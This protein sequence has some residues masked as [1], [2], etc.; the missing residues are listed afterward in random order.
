MVLLTSN[1][2]DTCASDRVTTLFPVYFR[3]VTGRLL[4]GYCETMTGIGGRMDRAP[5]GIL[6]ESV[7]VP[8]SL[9]CDFV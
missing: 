5:V 1:G 7:A 8:G 3:S 6:N 4:F 2:E 9:G